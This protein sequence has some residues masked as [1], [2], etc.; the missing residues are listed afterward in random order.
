MST[1]LAQQEEVQEQLARWIKNDPRRLRILAE[2][3]VAIPLSR[4]VQSSD[5]AAEIVRDVQD[6]SIGQMLRRFY[7]NEAITWEVF[8]WPQVEQL[9][10]SWRMPAYYLVIDT[11]DVGRAHRAVVLSLAYQQRSLPLLWQVEPGRKG[12][13]SEAVQVELLRK[14][15]S[16]FKPTKPVIFLG[17]SEFDGI[18]VQQLL[19]DLKW[20]YVLRTSPNLYLYPEDGQVA[21]QLATL[22]PTVDAPAQ[23][24]TQVDLTTKHRFGP[25][26]C[27][28]CWES[29][30]KQPLILVA[31]LP[32][33]WG[34][35]IPT[36]YKTRFWTEPLFGDFKEAGFRLS[37][38]QLEHE[39]RMARLFLAVASSYLWMVALGARLY[40]CGD[41]S[42]VDH[43]NRRT[44]SIFKTGWR[45]FKRQLKLDKIVAF[46]LF[47]P[48]SF[49]FPPLTFK[50][51]CVG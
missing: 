1:T 26:D 35:S 51:T 47:L 40:R 14:L 13:T 18:S 24:R 10:S 6:R 39:T 49:V 7:K 43:S 34:Y 21:V 33:Q 45:W 42:L 16:K 3:I 50:K 2:L 31:H 48:D 15:A 44:L 25:V 19:K 20:F 8:Y 41:V 27:Y 32:E 28:A 12:H 22:V 29:P 30:H 5:L 23:Q 4:S 9:L 38:S 17:D 36:T 11:T 37:Q 46:N